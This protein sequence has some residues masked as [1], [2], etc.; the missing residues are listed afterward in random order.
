MIC[1]VKGCNNKM[2]VI[3]Y[4]K[5]ICGHHWDLWCNNKEKL[6]KELHIKDVLK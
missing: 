2:E 6:I 5:Y 4:N 3:Y 1:K